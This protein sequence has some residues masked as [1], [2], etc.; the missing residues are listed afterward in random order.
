MD[1]LPEGMSPESLLAHFHEDEKV[2]HAV[3]PP[4]FQT[5]LFTFDTAEELMEAMLHNPA[6]PPDHYSRI[7]NPSMSVVE[8]KLAALEG[9]DK[10][11]VLG[12]GQAALTMAVLSETQ[13]GSHVVAVD[14]IYGP[15]RQLLTSY[16]PRFGVSVTYVDGLTPE[17]VI[18]AVTPETTLIYL[19]SPSSLVFRLQ[20]IEAIAKFAKQRGIT[21]M[22]D[23]TWATP[24]LQNP[25][26]LG[27]DIVCHSATKYLGGHSDLV[28]GV[29]CT[30]SERMEKIVRN[31]VNLLGSAL[32][33][34]P[35]WLLNRGMRTLPL[36]I[37]RHGQ[38]ALAVANWLEAHGSVEQVMHPGLESFPQRDLFQK[39]MRG[40]TGL[41]SFIPKDQTREKCFAFVNALRWFGKG[42]SWG[43]HESL[44]LP[45]PVT[46]LG[47]DRETWIIRCYCGMESA[48][49]LIADLKSAFE[50]SGL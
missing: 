39:Q 1:H 19:E 5:S 45:I 3:V 40:S 28:A 43:G 38:T 29:L 11:K 42:V 23:N 48:P 10:A 34:F 4:I 27:V 49:E 16:L 21:T 7:S 6:G 8:A 37:A 2:L 33:P 20:D 46:P 17:S 22:I 47:W 32:A 41:F 26:L 9:T 30:D 15:S 44:A 50:V 31:E 13:Q 35:A 12:S 36:R 18:D 25:A 24:L 14:T